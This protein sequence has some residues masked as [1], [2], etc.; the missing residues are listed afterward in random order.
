MTDHFSIIPIDVLLRI[1]LDQFDQKG[2]IFGISGNLFFRAKP[3]D[4]F[5]TALFDHTLET[6]I[7][8]AAGPHAQ[9]AQNIVAAWLCGA[10]FIEL[11]TVQAMDELDIS[12]PCIDMQDE[13]YNCEW[14]QEL[15][16][17]DSF[18][19]YLNA[20]I[21]LHILRHKLFG[22]HAADPGFIFNMSIGYDLKGILG[23]KIRWF[24]DNMTDA[25]E[26][27]R[28]KID[29]VRHI[30]PAIDELKIGHRLSDNVTLSTMHGCPPDEIGKI[31]EYL[32]V[33][34]QLHTS[35]KLNPTLLGPDRVRN[36]LSASGFG[37]TVPDI[38]FEH[39][40]QY[41]AAL[42]LIAK[43]RK[44]A[45][46][47]GL[48]FGLK[49]T[50]TLESLNHKGY[51]EQEKTMYLSGR[52][53]HPVSV[54]LAARLQKDHLG[55]LNISF[56]G[57]ANAVNTGHLYRCGLSPVTVCTDLL[58]PGGYGR[59]NQY[60][61]QLRSFTP[62]G[63]RQARLE[64][65]LNYAKDTLA[66]KAYQRT[67]IADINLKTNREL[68]YFD[69][70]EAPCVSACPTHQ[71][72]P[73]YL[74]YTATGDYD[75]AHRVIRETNPFPLI[76]GAICDHPCQLKCV[77]IHYDSPLQIR[78]V[79]RF[80]AE[81][82]RD[83]NPKG[84]E[85]ETR[86]PGNAAIIGAGPSGLSCAYFLAK[87]GLAV[88]V[89]ET[90]NAP[91]GMVSHAIPAFRLTGDDIDL[92]IREIQEM[93]VDI[94]CNQWIDTHKFGEL[95]RDFN[96]IYIAAGAQRSAQLNLPGMNSERVLDPLEFLFSV[97]KGERP[98]L[99]QHVV[100]VGGGNT[101]MD[102]A[103]TAWRLIPENGRV[104]IVYRRTLKQMP[105]DQ[106]EIRAVLAEGI[107]IVELAGPVALE[108]KENGQY[109]LKCQKMILGPPDASGRSRPLPRKG[110]WL[111]IPLDTL[112]P[113]IGQ[114][115]A[116]DFADKEQLVTEK[117]H[118]KTKIPGVFIGGDALRGASTA[119][120]AIGDG[121]KAADEMLS[122]MGF[123][124]RIPGTKKR[125]KADPAELMY[126]K[127][128]RIPSE[129]EIEE[130]YGDKSFRASG[131]KIT[132]ERIRQ[133]A[134]RCLKCDEICNL[135]TTVC[136][137][138][139]FHGYTFQPMS[140][141]LYEVSAS[142]ENIA[143]GAS[144]TYLVEQSHQILHIADWCNQCGNCTTF[145]PTKGSPFLDKPHLYL[146]EEAFQQEKDG[147]F[148]RKKGFSWKI[149]G[150]DQRKLF[151]LEESPGGFVYTTGDSRMLLSG[152]DLGILEI[153]AH[154]ENKK[155]TTKMAVILYTVLQ[156][157]IDFYGQR[158]HLK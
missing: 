104:T 113:A 134:A 127:T 98:E 63:N 100:I 52:A 22:Q 23:E 42:S 5:R 26:A 62:T 50:N 3:E 95:R 72:I 14:S 153:S 84:P 77:R 30:Y 13:G 136:P 146:N 149:M 88:T 89:F 44:K 49:L 154:S 36:I 38:A 78:E 86:K 111:N 112:I 82:A 155:T 56:S 67:Y 60:L 1:I 137:N 15:R 121:R 35:I 40:L 131:R 39:D 115:L 58:K 48:Q 116:I 148:V 138:L 69:C 27:L 6:P 9:L 61:E 24:L 144:G 135:C 92:D 83:H 81:Y 120:N 73:D 91:G 123:P 16:I 28:E 109:S 96:L 2:S 8:T 20:W 90:H 66:D 68:S 101:A 93:G 122:G 150:Y 71:S 132:A 87:R 151:T 142:R 107:Q 99:G 12:K 106:G 126:G 79:K 114:E 4:P 41:D 54:N 105:A 70:I 128:R 141:R 43:L 45:R 97:R 47:N 139:A 21:I 119:I 55:E 59:L 147:F 103:R 64:Q 94:R 133:E 80:V 18:D 76:T 129:L 152:E 29:Q 25:S 11:K 157:A 34:R 10:R 130:P 17:R 37:T 7:G 140:F 74:H 108:K 145:C 31:G 156:G 143:I 102:A 124:T 57:G 53:L 85:A 110:E 51:F 19:Q 65:L 117:G 125:P 33:N 32:I 75:Q 158:N 118:Y 46:K